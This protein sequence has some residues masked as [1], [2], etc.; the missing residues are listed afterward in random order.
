MGIIDDFVR[1]GEEQ[2]GIGYFEGD[3]Q[4]LSR[5]RA[6]TRKQRKKWKRDKQVPLN[7]LLHLRDDVR[8][9]DFDTNTLSRIGKGRTLDNLPEI[10]RRHCCD[11]PAARDTVEYLCALIHKERYP[12]PEPVHWRFRKPVVRDTFESKARRYQ[13][14]R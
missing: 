6:M 1:S 9:I 8:A 12:K 10:L 4:A 14:N 13:T 3:D 5:S 7:F 2:R 11:H